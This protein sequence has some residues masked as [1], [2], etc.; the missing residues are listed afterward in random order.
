[1]ALAGG[2][3]R[4]VAM[5]LFFFTFGFEAASDC[6]TAATGAAMESFVARLIDAHN[7]LLGAWREQLVEYTYTLTGA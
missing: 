2:T 6:C 5:D 1:M 3:S 7:Q 4:T